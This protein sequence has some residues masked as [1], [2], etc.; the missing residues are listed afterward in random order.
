[1]VD[2]NM[3]LAKY[4]VSKNEQGAANRCYIRSSFFIFSETKPLP[5][6]SNVCKTK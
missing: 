1:M 4:K 5:P 3:K 2:K 6:P